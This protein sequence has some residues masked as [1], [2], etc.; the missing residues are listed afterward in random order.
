MEVVPGYDE[1]RGTP[2]QRKVA[3]PAQA[4]RQ[5]V[6]KWCHIPEGPAEG[7]VGMKIGHKIS[8]PIRVDE[9]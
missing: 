1:C 7:E 9:E 6:E 8:N 4:E 3:S 2:S 5:D